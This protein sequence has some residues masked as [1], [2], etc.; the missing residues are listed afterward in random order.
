MI[1]LLVVLAVA[2]VGLG[3]WSASTVIESR[4]AAQR[5]VVVMSGYDKVDVREQEMM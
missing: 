2:A 3:A 4:A 1:A 5:S